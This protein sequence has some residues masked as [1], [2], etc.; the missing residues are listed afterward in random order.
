MSAEPVM[1][2]E[3]VAL[4]ESNNVHAAVVEK[5]RKSRCTKISTFAMWFDDINT[6]VAPFLES[7]A[8]VKEDMSQ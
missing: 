6:G 3:L 8:E 5:F 7:V 4:F 1:E 2:A